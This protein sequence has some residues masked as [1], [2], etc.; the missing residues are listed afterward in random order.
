MGNRE[1]WGIHDPSSTILPETRVGDSGALQ[2]QVDYFQEM[3]AE[4]KEDSTWEKQKEGK[5]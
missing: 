4:L 1:L 3:T 2:L 5:D